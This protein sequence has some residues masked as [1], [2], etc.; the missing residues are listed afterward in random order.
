[1]TQKF[2][3]AVGAREAPRVILTLMHLLAFHYYRKG[4]RYR[5]GNAAGSD[6]AHQLGAYDYARTTAGYLKLNPTVIDVYLPKAKFNL[7]H[8]LSLARTVNIEDHPL[9]QA[10]YDLVKQVHPAYSKLDGFG[11]NAHARNALQV[12]GDNLD[13]PSMGVLCWAPIDG[14]SVLGGTRTAVEI[15]RLYGIK[16]ANL[17][18]RDTY[19][20]HLRYLGISEERLIQLSGK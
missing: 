13:L 10:C 16:I 8:D 3:T 1:M 18:D 7:H 2:I 12:L 15:A 11:R 9:K 14:D 19:L 6:Y 4:Y 20:R 5:T 17:A